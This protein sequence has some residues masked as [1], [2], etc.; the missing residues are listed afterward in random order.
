MLESIFGTARSG[1]RPPHWT[2]RFSEFADLEY[3]ARNGPSKA[4]RP[5]RH[6]FAPIRLN[7]T[8]EALRLDGVDFIDL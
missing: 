7:S 5:A 3:P 2:G 4:K 8:F 1:R 6:R